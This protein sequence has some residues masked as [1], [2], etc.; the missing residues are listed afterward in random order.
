M[1]DEFESIDSCSEY[2][3]S[4][5]SEENE[6]VDDWPLTSTQMSAAF[7]RDS[8]DQLELSPVTGTQTSVSFDVTSERKEHVEEQSFG[9]TSQYYIMNLHSNCKDV[10]VKPKTPKPKRGKFHV[11]GF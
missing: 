9:P 11:M 1:L 8:L 10:T 6:L 3:K 7:S 5:A 4:I 2:E